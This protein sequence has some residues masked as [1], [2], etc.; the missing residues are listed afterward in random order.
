[1]YLYNQTLLAFGGRR[2]VSNIDDDDSDGYES[3]D[4][5]HRLERNFGHYFNKAEDDNPWTQIR[6]R[7]KLNVDDLQ[8]PSA[9]VV[10]RDIY[11][12][13]GRVGG[14]VLH[15][16]GVSKTKDTVAN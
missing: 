3:D 14:N 10:N 5:T 7:P 2:V 9:V 8:Y 11:L 15:L 13:G 6:Y 12:A 16:P 1:M 4:S